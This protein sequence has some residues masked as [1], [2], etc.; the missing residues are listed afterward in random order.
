MVRAR[1][2]VI[3]RD[4]EYRTIRLLEHSIQ[5]PDDESPCAAPERNASAGQAR[6]KKR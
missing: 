6:G 1:G 3:R 2:L 5:S 4:Q